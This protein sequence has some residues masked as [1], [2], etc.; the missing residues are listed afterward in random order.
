MA[1]CRLVVEAWVRGEEGSPNE[2]I[3][4]FSN[5][6]AIGV[7]FISGFHGLSGGSTNKMLMVQMDDL[8]YIRVNIGTYNGSLKGPTVPVQRANRLGRN[9][10]FS[11]N[12]SQTSYEMGQASYEMSRTSYEMSRTSYEMSQTSY[13]MS[14]TSYEMSR[15]SYKMRLILYEISLDSYKNC[16][17]LRGSPPFLDALPAL[18]HG[19][20]QR[21]GVI[22][23]TPKGM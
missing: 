7:G 8:N 14:Q 19:P 9:V 16:T 11:Y 10:P 13:K 21:W 3:R 12:M 22:Y 17:F 5:R 15:T 23:H 2:H 1:F 20:F 18:L 4:L 6:T